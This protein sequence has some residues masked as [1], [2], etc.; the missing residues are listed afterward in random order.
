MK[1]MWS[2]LKINRKLIVAFLLITILSSASGLISLRL[3]KVADTRYSNALVNYGFA[4]GDIGLLMEA[5]KNNTANVVMMMATNDPALKKE[6]QE[7]IAKNSALIN[8]YMTSVEKTLIGDQEKEYYNTIKENLPKFTEHATEVISLADNDRNKEAMDLYQNEA[9]EHIEIIEDAIQKLMDS[10]RTVGSQLSEELTSQS[11]ITLVSM[12]ILILVSLI[13]SMTLATVISRSISKPMAECSERLVLLSHGDLQTPI[14]EVNSQDET[15]VLASAT[16]ELTER[17]SFLIKEISSV[18]SHVAQ[19][20]LDIP[21]TR[22]F[23]G[24]FA[25]LHTD[26]S[27]IIDSLNEAFQLIMQAADQVDIGSDQVSIGAQSLSQ[28]ATEQASSIQ[29][30]AA[31]VNEISA[32]VQKNAGNAQEARQEAEKQGI[33]LNASN[34]KMQEMVAAMT[35]INNKSGEIEKIIK[36][37]ED[38]AFQTNILALNAAIEAARAGE[39]GKGFAVVADEVRSLAAKSGEAAKDTTTLIS[40]TIDAVDQ[41]SAIATATADAL[42]E[43]VESSRHVAE[44]VDLIAEASRDQATSINQVTIG[45]NQIS[46]VVQSTTATAEESAAASEELSG[47]AKMM[48]D[49][50]GKFKLKR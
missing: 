42:N 37:I 21:Y 46:N 20:N 40:E 10:N 27:K 3:M 24:D 4:Q 14:P 7:D 23:S 28:G 31:T 48:K 34:G 11:N 50:V 39:A 35:Q 49:L 8:Q 29:E 47:Q 44:L 25:P 41:G 38:I 26:S 18:L 19:G 12:C 30:L 33:N 9:L 16:K 6:A 36:T 1:Q 45:M 32:Q 2:K 5:L 22:E 15:G 43:V 13:I 17:L